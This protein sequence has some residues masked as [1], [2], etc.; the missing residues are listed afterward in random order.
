MSKTREELMAIA[1]IEPKVPFKKKKLTE[2]DVV[3]DFIEDEKLIPNDKIPIPA[4]MVYVRYLKWCSFHGIEPKGMSFFFSRFKLHFNSKLVRQ[5]RH[6]FIEP[7]GF[8]LSP[9]GLEQAK[10]E[11][12]KQI[13]GKKAEKKSKT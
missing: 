13:S 5:L 4:F 3:K 7:D 11:Y 2:V 9:A 12:E 6:Y 1:R 8:D 10:R